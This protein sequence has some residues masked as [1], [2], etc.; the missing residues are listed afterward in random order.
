MDTVRFPIFQN[1]MITDILVEEA[2]LEGVRR[3]CGQV[4]EDLAQVTGRQ[5]AVHDMAEKCAKHFTVLAAT[6]GHSPLLDRLA[7]QEMVSLAGVTVECHGYIA[8]DAAHVTIFLF[9]PGILGSF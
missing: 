2:A 3:I 8:I 6:V 5:C 7:A 9:M 4:R 1:D